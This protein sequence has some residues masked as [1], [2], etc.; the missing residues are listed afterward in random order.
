MT[1][2]YFEQNH[3]KR[4]N[5]WYGPIV[6]GYYRYIAEVCM[7]EP[8]LLEKGASVLDIGCGVAHWYNSLI[9]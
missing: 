3:L 2:E 5:S 6:K 9:I 4:L 7:A 8:A 1:D